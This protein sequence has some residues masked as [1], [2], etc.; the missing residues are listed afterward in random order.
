[1]SFPKPYTTEKNFLTI[2]KETPSFNN[3][4]RYGNYTSEINPLLNKIDIEWNKKAKNYNGVKPPDPNVIVNTNLQKPKE[5]D[6]FQI[7]AREPYKVQYLKNKYGG[8]S[9][10]FGTNLG[11]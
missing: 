6:I 1:M 4:N 10:R 11:N 3:R 9:T 8:L 2:N 5:W 7:D